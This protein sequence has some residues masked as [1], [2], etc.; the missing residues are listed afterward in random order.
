MVLAALRGYVFACGPC[1]CT[2]SVLSP[3]AMLIFIV[4]WLSMM[5]SE[6]HA[7]SGDSVD[8]HGPY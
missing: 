4:L 1:G 6:V 8:V 2:L 5:M 3:K 7:T